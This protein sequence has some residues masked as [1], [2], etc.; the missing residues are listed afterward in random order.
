M[1]DPWLVSVSAYISFL[2]MLWSGRRMFRYQNAHIVV[3][4]AL[5]LLFL[6]ATLACPTLSVVLL[7]MGSNT[8]ML[9]FL[10]LASAI[11]ITGAVLLGHWLETL[12]SVPLTTPAPPVQT[13]ECVVCGYN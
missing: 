3:V 9:A 10:F 11:V 8:A 2:L 5:A 7:A 6:A 4:T 13:G 12:R 1:R